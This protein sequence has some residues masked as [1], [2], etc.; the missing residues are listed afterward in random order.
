[1]KL[2]PDFGRIMLIAQKWEIPVN[3]Q[4][5]HWWCLFSQASTQKSCSHCPG[6]VTR[7]PF[8]ARFVHIHQYPIS[9]TR[10]IIR[11]HWS[12]Y[13]NMLMR[14]YW[15]IYLRIYQLRHDI[16]DCL[17]SCVVY[18]EWDAY[19]RM[20]ILSVIQLFTFNVNVCSLSALL[21]YLY[22]VVLYLLEC[23]RHTHV[24]H[25]SNLERHRGAFQH[26]Q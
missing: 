22:P 11:A 6:P 18:V 13:L 23:S 25:T 1:M 16:T 17:N 14:T 4:D 15:Y 2:V 8:K 20:R 9:L 12:V 24:I 26:S 10:I 21:Y 19:Y 3:E 5:P 7:G